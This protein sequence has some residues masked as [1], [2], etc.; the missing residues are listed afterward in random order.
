MIQLTVK[1]VDADVE[2]LLG[3][4]NKLSHLKPIERESL[5]DRT[6][7]WLRLADQFSY[8]LSSDGPPDVQIDMNAIR[9]PLGRHSGIQSQCEPGEGPLH[10]EAELASSTA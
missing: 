1:T 7:V 3:Y 2:A 8:P 6:K 5:L 4:L 9:E 10:Q